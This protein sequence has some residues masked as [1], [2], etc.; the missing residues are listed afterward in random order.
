MTTAIA[1]TMVGHRRRSFGATSS[2]EAAAPAP[3]ESLVMPKRYPAVDSA[4]VIASDWSRTG[5]PVHSVDLTTGPPNS[6]ERRVGLGRE[7]LNSCVPRVTAICSVGT[8]KQSPRQPVSS[9]GTGGGFDLSVWGR[10]L[11]SL[12]PSPTRT[13][14]EVEG[15][16]LHLFG[17]Q[18]FDRSGFEQGGD[19]MRSTFVRASLTSH[20]AFSAYSIASS[21]L[22]L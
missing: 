11:R 10:L 6:V 1:A 9:S 13:P 2:D 14:T 17:T 7:R 15:S 16:P 19:R 12:F 20:P 4:C 5:L 21:I 8:S 3:R 18:R 22:S